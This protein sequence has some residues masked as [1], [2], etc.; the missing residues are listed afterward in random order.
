[1]TLLYFAW[2]RQK[3]GAAQET[4]ELPPSVKTVRDL[5]EH[6]QKRGGGF[7]EAFADPARLRAAVNQEHAVFDAPVSDNEEVAIFPPVTGG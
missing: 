6:L 7:L 4:I 5:V 3:V 2:I 1:V